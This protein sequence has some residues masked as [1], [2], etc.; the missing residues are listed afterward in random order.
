[1]SITDNVTWM[2]G[3][4]PTVLFCY[5]CCFNTGSFHSLNICSLHCFTDKNETWR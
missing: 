5:H 3:E 1:M 4:H 2:A